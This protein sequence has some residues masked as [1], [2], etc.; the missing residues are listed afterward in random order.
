MVLLLEMFDLCV[1][2][3]M[4]GPPTCKLDDRFLCNLEEKLTFYCS[5]GISYVAFDS[6]SSS[7]TAILNN[8]IS[9]VF[10]LLLKLL[11]R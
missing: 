11:Q 10:C 8:A 1:C 6:I 9:S 2:Q 3:R 4:L 5:S 7:G